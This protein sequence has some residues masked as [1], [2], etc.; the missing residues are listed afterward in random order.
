MPSGLT[1]SIARVLVLCEDGVVGRALELLLRTADY[2]VRFLDASSLEEL[3]TLDGIRLVLICPGFSTEH[4]TTLLTLIESTPVAA[5]I[6]ILELVE[7]SDSVRAGT[8]YLL[9]WPCRA[10][11][12]KGQINAVLLTNPE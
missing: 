12:L 8:T 7:N 1:P 9:P 5:E 2:D 3:E 4:R 11:D 6:S 10:D